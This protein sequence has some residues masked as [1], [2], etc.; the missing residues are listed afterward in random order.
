MCPKATAEVDKITG[1]YWGTPKDNNQIINWENYDYPNTERPYA[2]EF[3]LEEETLQLK[4]KGINSLN[5]VYILDVNNA[6][7]SAQSYDSVGV[8]YTD[9]SELV[10]NQTS[11]AWYPFAS[12]PASGDYLYL[13]SANMFHSIN[14][15]SVTNGVLSTSESNVVQYYDGSDWVNITS[16]ESATGVLNLTADGKVSWNRLPS[17][18]QTTINTKGPHYYIRI[19]NLNTYST[20]PKLSMVYMGQDFVVSEE[21]DLYKIRF[22]NWG[23]LVFAQNTFRNGKQRIRVDFN[24]GY[25]EVPALIEELTAVVGGIMSLVRVSGGSYDTPSTYTL[26]RKNFSIGQLYINI[27][28]SLKQLRLR[29]ESLLDQVGRKMDVV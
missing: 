4:Y 2:D 19:K 23:E 3:P 11:A 27:D 24:H 10:N 12:T 13:G 6:F 7:V 25:S 17:W 15:I 9:N 14:I 29:Y 21:V 22:Q 18:T 16:T 8:S 28:N 26:G 1:N 20:A 5:G